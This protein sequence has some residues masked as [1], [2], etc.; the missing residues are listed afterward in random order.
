MF[1]D[2]HGTADYCPECLGELHEKSMAVMQAENKQLQLLAD[3]RHEQIKE[4]G[5][6]IKSLQSVVEKTDADWRTECISFFRW[7]WNQD[8]TNT[9]RGYDDW[10]AQGKPTLE[11]TPPHTHRFMYFG[12]QKKRR[13][14]DCNVVE[15]E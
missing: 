15:G 1:C 14:A 8:G 9:E 5:A 4:D 3:S 10:V 12:D 11:V 7:W 2:E 6:T 13:C